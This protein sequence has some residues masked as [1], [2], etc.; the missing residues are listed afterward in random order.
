MNLIQ[1]LQ[2][3]IADARANHHAMADTM[4]VRQQTES[5]AWIVGMQK[6]LSAMIADGAKACDGCGN[7][8]M[9]LEHPTKHGGVEYEIGCITCPPFE[10]TDGTVRECRVRGGMLPRHAVE[11]WNEGPDMWLKRGS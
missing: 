7:V 4:T 8:P 11:A 5:G 2:G 3:E 10:H 1:K 6:E 9:G